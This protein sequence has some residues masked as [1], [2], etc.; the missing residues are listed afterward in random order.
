MCR[1]TRTPSPKSPRCSASPAGGASTLL[2]TN[3][4]PGIVL[5]LSN[6]AA[7]NRSGPPFPNLVPSLAPNDTSGIGRNPKAEPETAGQKRQTGLADTRKQTLSRGGHCTPRPRLN[8]PCHQRASAP[9]SD[10]RLRTFLQTRNWIARSNQ[11]ARGRLTFRDVAIE[12]SQEE[13]ECLDPAQRSLYRDVMLETYRNLVSLGEDNFPPEVGIPSDEF[14]IKELS[15]TENIN[16]G[17]F[18][19]LVI[20][21]RNGSHGIKDFDLQEVWEDMHEFESQWGYD[22]RNYKVPLTHNKNFICRKDQQ[23]NQSSVTL[24]KKQSVSVRNNTYQ[25][26]MGGEPFIR[27]LLKLDKNRIGAGNQYVNCLE[28]RSGLSLQAHRAEL[29]RFHSEEKMYECNPTEKSVSNGSSVSPLQGIPPSTKNI[30][31]KSR[32]ILKYPLLPAQDRRG[33]ATGKSYKCN[34]CG[35]AFSKSSNLMSH[36]RIHCGQRPYKCNDC[37]KAFTDRSNLTRHKKIHTG[38]KPYKCNEC[39]KAFTQCANLTRHLKIH[40]GEKPHKCNVCDKA[41]NQSSSLM[42]HRRIHT[43]EKPYKCSKCGKAFIKRSDLWGHERTHTGEKPYKCSECGKAFAERSNLT[44][45]R[46]IHTGEKPYTCNE[47]GKAFTQFASLWGHERTHTGEKPYKCNECGKAF[48]HFATLN[49]HRKI[50]T[51]E[52][53]HKCNVCDKDFIRSSSLTRH[54]RIHTREKPYK[55]NKCDK[56]YIK[57]SDLWCHERMHIGEKQML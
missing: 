9:P 22:T 10:S 36:E 45:H 21:E 3:V 18:Y 46:K 31:N 42:A 56:A 29:Q 35:K 48:T 12:F 20:L 25:Y 57:H 13:W 19:H 40:T 17:E 23:L 50:H 39:G 38:E 26:F 27:T 15:P 54:Q 34:D 16:K 14:A 32:K 41:F 8:P 52:K 33:Y 30:W 24:P 2:A 51:G 37:G 11:R 28:N 6:T 53:P 4:S 47:C 5:N 7:P 49:T 43:G 44:Q 1:P 55:C